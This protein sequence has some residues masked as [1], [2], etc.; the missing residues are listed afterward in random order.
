MSGSYDESWVWVSEETDF[1]MLTEGHQWLSSRHLFRHVVPDTRTSNREIPLTEQLK[2]W[3]V[4]TIVIKHLLLLLLLFLFHHIYH[5]PKE[6]GANWPSLHNAASQ[7]LVLHQ[8]R[9]IGQAVFLDEFARDSGRH[10]SALRWNEKPHASVSTTTHCTTTRV[11]HETY[12]KTA[13]HTTTR[14]AVAHKSITLINCLSVK[15]TN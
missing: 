12:Q 7:S 13:K 10:T 8:W 11:H 4:I 2:A 14:T 1:Q 5:L 6:H 3:W 9:W 15:T